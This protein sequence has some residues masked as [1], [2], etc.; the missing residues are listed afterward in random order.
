MV[1]RYR[2]HWVN[3]DECDMVDS[4]SRNWKGA[5]DSQYV[6]ATDYDA[7]KMECEALQVE[8]KCHAPTGIYDGRDIYSW[9]QEAEALRVEV[10]RLEE[11][12]WMYKDLCQ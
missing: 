5:E 10:K 3:C 6:L 9:M 2:L 1:K 7:L 11:Y 4:T 8:L 12:E